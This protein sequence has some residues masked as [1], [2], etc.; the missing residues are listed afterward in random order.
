MIRCQIDAVIA[1]NHDEKSAVRCWNTICC[2]LK[3]NSMQPNQ[4][5]TKTQHVLAAAQQFALERQHPEVTEDHLLAAL[6]KEDLQ[7][8]PFLLQQSGV[9]QNTIKTINEKQC[10]SYATVSDNQPQFSRSAVSTLQNALKFAHQRGDHYVATQHLLWA[11]SQSKS[12]C[13]QLLRDQGLQKEILEKAIDVLQKGEQVNS[14]SAEEQYNALEKYAKNLNALAR[15]N[16]LDPVI[17]R[18]DEIRRVLQ[19]LSRRT[20]NNPILVGE[21]GTGKTAI[22]EGLAHRIIEGDIPENLKK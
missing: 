3:K 14:T 9:Q 8:V 7:V 18:D 5:T 17:G 12:S 11:L 13:G 15:E 1:G 16:K 2:L 6:L 10:A 19:I 20:K 22:A 21:P 4:L